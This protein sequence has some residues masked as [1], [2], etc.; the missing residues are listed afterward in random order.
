MVVM[1][2]LSN[3]PNQSLPLRGNP[4]SVLSES[5]VQVQTPTSVNQI[6]EPSLSAKA[7]FAVDV[8]SGSVLFAK[9]PDEPILPAS[10]T[11]IVTALVSLDHY[12][13]DEPLTVGNTKVTGSTMG[14]L[15]GEKITALNLIYGLLISSSNDAAEVLAANYPGGRDNFVA[16]MNRLSENMGLS[17]TNFVNPAGFDAYLHFSTARDLADLAI[18]AINKYPIFAS[19][20]ST[21]METVTSFDGGIRHELV[22]TN[23]LLGKTPGV[24]GVK[25]GS[26]ANSGES[27]VTLVDRDNHKVMISILGSEDRFTETEAL[28][29]WIYSSYSWQ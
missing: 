6:P 18:Y 22:S 16:A 7:V 17:K 13:L 27:L 3:F 14:L 12:N 25:T 19:I 29:E 21:Q 26:T 4:K 24:I 15:P 1:G 10:T 23:K 28:L 11:K 5:T 9:N 8:A 20:V 2:L